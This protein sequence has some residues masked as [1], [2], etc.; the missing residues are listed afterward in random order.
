MSLVQKIKHADEDHLFWGNC[1]ASFYNETSN[2]VESALSETCDENIVFRKSVANLTLLSPQ[3]DL[4]IQEP[5][6]I[7]VID[8]FSLERRILIAKNGSWPF[9]ESF[10]AYEC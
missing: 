4:V 6:T 5:S 1:C 8:S 7:A 2:L 10:E 3:E 9:P